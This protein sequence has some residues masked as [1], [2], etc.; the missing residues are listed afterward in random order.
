M[1]K[2]TISLYVSVCLCVW[3]CLSAWNNSTPTGRIRWN[4]IF[5]GFFRKSVKKI[6]VSLKSDKNNEH[7]TWRIFHIYDIWLNSFRVKN[8]LDKSCRQNRNTHFTFNNFLRK[9]HRLWDKVEKSGRARGATNDVT[10]WRIHVACWIRKSICTHAHERAWAPTRKYAR[11]EI[12]NTY[13]FL[14]ATMTRE[15]ASVLRHT[16]IAYTVLCKLWLLLLQYLFSIYTV[17]VYRN[18]SFCD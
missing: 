8:V 11:T 16:H 3:V 13:C 9:S 6:Q 4:L 17:D 2:A 7:F 5:T 10:I 12:R 14:S 1:R 18:C 15:R